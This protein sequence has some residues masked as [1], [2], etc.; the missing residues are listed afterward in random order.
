M[1]LRAGEV[2]LRG[3]EALARHEPQVR[4]ESAAQE[5]ARLGV[6]AAEDALDQAVAVNASISEAAR[7]R[8]VCR[9][10]RR[11]RSL[12]AGCRPTEMSASGA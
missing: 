12:A 1:R 2:L 6:A 7:R 11:S 3:A 5:H 10:R 9:G 4:L 8:Q